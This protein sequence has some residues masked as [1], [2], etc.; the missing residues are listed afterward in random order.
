MAK[1]LIP[2]WRWPV[3]DSNGNLGCP[4]VP[5]GT[6]R[7]KVRLS[8]ELDFLRTNF[9][10]TFSIFTLCGI[11]TSRGLKKIEFIATKIMPFL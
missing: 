4:D 7:I 5:K 3:T 2:Y 9:V 11:S 10:H 6:G 8:L 1:I